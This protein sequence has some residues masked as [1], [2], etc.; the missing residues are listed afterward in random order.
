MADTLMAVL[1]TSTAAACPLSEETRWRRVPRSGAQ[2]VL[3]LVTAAILQALL[4]VM[5]QAHQE[6]APLHLEAG[7]SVETLAG[8]LCRIALLMDLGEAAADL[9]GGPLEARRM[10]GGAAA[11][12]RLAALVLQEA[13]AR[14]AARR[15]PPSRP[16]AILATT[17]GWLA[18]Y[19][20]VP[21]SALSLRPA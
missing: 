16:L 20:F 10:P 21:S 19:F 13:A 3:P 1:A 18:G 9:L 4:E 8:R 17:F 2:F 11:D 14:V 15:A 12:S 6:V 5:L 7:I